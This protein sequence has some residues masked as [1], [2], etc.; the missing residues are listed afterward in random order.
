MRDKNTHK[1]K[2]DQQ[3]INKIF[4]FYIAYRKP[5]LSLQFNALH[6]LNYQNTVYYSQSSGSSSYINSLVQSVGKRQPP[7]EREKSHHHSAHPQH[8]TIKPNPK[9]CPIEESNRIERF[10]YRSHKSFIRWILSGE[11]RV[12]VKHFLVNL[13]KIVRSVSNCIRLKRDLSRFPLVL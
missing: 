10:V 4:H 2:F 1:R 3:F 12:F 9:L 5:T 7:N 8:M 13:N 6:H 11:N